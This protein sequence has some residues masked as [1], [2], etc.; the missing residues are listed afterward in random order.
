MT[1]LRTPSS[2]AQTA[3]RI[4]CIVSFL[5][6][7]R[8]LG[9]F[10]D[11]IA[12]QERFPDL[13][14]LVDDGSTDASAA[15]AA[16]FASGRGDVRLLRRA[17]RAQ[18]RDRLAQA[19]ELRA[20]QWALAEIGERWD[21]VAKM[22]ADLELNRD[23]FDTLERAFL[24]TP[25]LGIAGAH[26]SVIDPR[27]GA[28][29]HERCPPHHVRGATKF[30][31]RGCLQEISPIPPILG[32]DTIDEIAARKHGWRT[33]TIACPG[34]GAIH[35][36]PTGS[37][38]GMLQ[39]QYRWGACAY[40]IGQHP[41]WIL[42]SAARRLGDRPRLVGAAAF[43]AGWAS[44]AV[45]HRPRAASDVRAFGRREQLSIVRRRVRR[46]IAA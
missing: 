41:L 6:E 31:R 19:A 27:T 40:G 5:N 1:P 29:V 4:V 7:Q 16:E 35:L 10:L 32:W 21:I 25:K 30:Y 44:A 39:A 18:A 3:L 13:L 42:L 8:H 12:R 17:P 38:D 23:L 14:M 45:R 15:I 22:D 33:A 43:L 20:F 37:S 9:A 36:R 26:L 2:P 28:Q 34:G 11:S 46:T 24:M